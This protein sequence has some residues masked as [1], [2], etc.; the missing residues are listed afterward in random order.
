MSPDDFLRRHGRNLD[1]LE[2]CHA[3]DTN[4]SDPAFWDRAQVRILVAFLSVGWVRS[5]SGT[6]N[7]LKSL[8]SRRY[9]LKV[10]V[11]ACYYPTVRDVKIYAQ[12][13]QEFL[14][15]NASHRSH[16]EYDA[17]FVSFAVLPEV[18]NYPYLL[19]A[20]GISPDWDVR[21]ESQGPLIVGG[22]ACSAFMD[23]LYGEREGGAGCLVDA[24]Y[25]GA[26]ETALHQ[27]VDV[28]MQG[29][30][31]K[32][33]LCA[34]AQCPGML[35][36]WAY[37]YEFEP[38]PDTGY[39]IKNIASIREVP[40]E[41][42]Y[43][44]KTG[45]YRGELAAKVMNVAGDAVESG[46][47]E[48]STG[49]GCSN[50]C[51]F[52][53]EGGTGRYED[54]SLSMAVEQMRLLR[55]RAAP[56]GLSFFSYNINYY[57]RFTDLLIAAAKRFDHVALS[58]QRADVIAAAPEYL[59]LAKLAGLHKIS[60]AVEGM[61]ERIRNGLLNKNLSRAQL[62]EAC[63]QVLRHRLAELKLC[64]IVTGWET[65][66][67]EAESLEEIAQII[68]IRDHCGAKTAVRV[69]IT[70]LLHYPHTPLQYLERRVSLS[71]LRGE[72]LL[73]RYLRGLKDLGVRVRVHAK[74]LSTVVT[75]FILD[76]GRMGTRYLWEIGRERSY[77]F[78]ALAMALEKRLL[79]ELE[80]SG[81]HL[82]D[83][84]K[85]KPEEFVFWHYPVKVR[86]DAYLWQAAVRCEE[87]VPAVPC[88]RT[89][90]NQDPACNGCGQCEDRRER[91]QILKREIGSEGNI[92][93]L[94]VVLNQNRSNLMLRVVVS[95]RPEYF[96][97]SSAMLSHRIAAEICRLNP[98]AEEMFHRVGR[99]SLYWVSQK[100]QRD[101]IS[102][103]FVFPIFFRGRFSLKGLSNRLKSCY[104]HVSDF[105]PP[106]EFVQ[107]DLVTLYR[108]DSGVP[109]AE[110]RDRYALFDNNVLVAR[111]HSARDLKTG[112]RFMGIEHPP[113]AMDIQGRGIYYLSLPIA[114]NPFL[115]MASVL[116]IR[117][118]DAWK[119]M[120]VISIFVL[121]CGDTVC[122][123]CGAPVY[124]DVSGGV[125]LKDCPNCVAK[126]L[127]RRELNLPNP[128]SA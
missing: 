108:V 9:G 104:F 36:P 69:V 19:A 106:Q 50:T 38:D 73:V 93:Q 41:V 62:L 37:S 20:N 99:N 92:S 44:N 45:P 118:R 15:G 8:L 14:F 35:L 79:P 65:S 49:C 126:Q 64:I 32:E 71:M 84:F 120:R 116:R 54:V 109:V 117:P 87:G 27:V 59:E 12:A 6:F 80:G 102:G 110:F 74:S 107:R 33:R 83:F 68:K 47:I 125:V 105:M 103:R 26:A 127:I 128:I 31:K 2:Y 77:F 89:A 43:Q 5:L 60:L 85:A 4:S 96:F 7:V 61:G 100:N 25:V 3:V 81:F 57:N 23:I 22:G 119:T 121:A 66:E 112:R 82:C 51:S 24:M 34:M 86:P 39:R 18:W 13:Q 75:Q 123:I 52:C 122:R 1:T 17:V 94:R 67:D 90:V 29:G 16:R 63:R 124:G 113:V 28:L 70:P 72:K 101:W 58:T 88:L 30:T 91:D 97:V 78:G 111:Q 98:E 40:G 10:F 95:L 55:R 48:V 11:D 76:A 56:N 114:V 46:T 115:Y 53:F 42:R 21:M